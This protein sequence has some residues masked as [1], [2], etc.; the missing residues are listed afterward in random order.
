MK[1]KYSSTYLIF[2]DG[3][4]R[5]IWSM[6]I[7]V[8]G[9]IKEIDAL[10][11]NEGNEL[12][13]DCIPLLWWW[14]I[15]NNNA[16]IYLPQD[17]GPWSGW[18]WWPRWWWRRMLRSRLAAPRSLPRPTPGHTDLSRY[19]VDIECLLS[20]KWVDTDSLCRYSLSRYT[21]CITR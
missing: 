15:D 10:I 17:T 11:K 12:Y 8:T 3:N 9:G 2:N 16:D 4:K 5:Y 13:C 7:P 18:G 6:Q 21:H 20:R 19:T 14:A 1:I